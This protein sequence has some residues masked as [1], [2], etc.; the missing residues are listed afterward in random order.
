MRDTVSAR[1]HDLGRVCLGI[2]LPRQLDPP[3]FESPVIVFASLTRGPSRSRRRRVTAQASSLLLWQPHHR[4]TTSPG[5]WERGFSGTPV[6]TNKDAIIR[7]IDPRPACSPT[8]SP[9]SVK[10]KS[11]SPVDH[12]LPVPHQP[13]PSLGSPSE[14]TRRR[15]FLLRQGKGLHAHRRDSYS[16][17]QADGCTHASLTEI[18]NTSRTQGCN[19]L[20]DRAQSL[21]ELA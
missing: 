10:A 9:T 3:P 14:N 16:I 2:L 11:T 5:P 20:L 1:T 21:R 18:S 17:R 8:S 19:L 12:P 13:R 7:L 4:Y 15:S 6:C